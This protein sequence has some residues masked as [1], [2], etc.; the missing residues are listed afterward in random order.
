MDVNIMVCNAT[1]LFWFSVIKQSWC[2]GEPF[3]VG[4]M[5]HLC[6]EKGYRL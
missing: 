1:P 2:K 3:F 4:I 5:Q 6:V